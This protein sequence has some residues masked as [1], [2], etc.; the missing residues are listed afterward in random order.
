MSFTSMMVHQNV[1]AHNDS[2]LQIAANL[3]QRFGAKL[4]GIAACEVNPPAYASGAFAS[5]IFNELRLQTES[6]LKE[7][8]VRF[9]ASAEGNV[10]EI[11]W[12]QAFAKP[13]AYVAQEG[14]AADVIITGAARDSAYF[15]PFTQ[16]DPG[17]LIMQA[18]RPVL[19]VPPE[20]ESLEAK[21]VLVAW[22]DTREAR[23]AVLDALPFLQAATDVTVVEVGSRA[24]IKYAA[25]RGEDVAGW[26]E[27]HGVCAAA[28]AIVA[29]EQPFEALE[30]LLLQN[31]ADLVV[32]GAYGHSRVQEWIFGGVT[33]DLLTKARCCCLFAH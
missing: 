31:A 14:R 11:E 27:R 33:R 2:R 16:L 17:D 12:R 25:R 8:A 13:I 20:A 1:D 6:K 29:S 15:D 4:I 23:R 30:A 24:E 21:H 5:A 22:K 10:R 26:L 18:G 7:A 32:A 3:A 28:N 9:S 19:I